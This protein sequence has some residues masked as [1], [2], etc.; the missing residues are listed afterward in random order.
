MLVV[1]ALAF[2]VVAS[3]N[4]STSIRSARE[5]GQGATIAEFGRQVTSL[6]HELQ[7]ERD[8]SAGFVSS[9]RP[10][11]QSSP[12]PKQLAQ[13]QESVKLLG[14]QVHNTDRALSAFRNARAAVERE[15]GSQAQA[16]I[17]RA[18][19]AL[20]DLGTLRNAVMTQKLTVA[21]A[22][23]QY[24]GMV[25][26]LQDV[27]LEIGQRGGSRE[28]TQSVTALTDLSRAKEAASQV[29]GLLYS[30]AYVDGF[31]FK[32]VQQLSAAL[33]DQQAALDR[34]RADA[35]TEQRAV[36]DEQVNGQAVI[37]VRRI[38]DRAVDRQQTADLQIDPQQWYAAATTR[39]EL[40]RS[41]ESS[42]LDSVIA[43]AR[44]LRS[45]AQRSAISTG[46]VIAAI[47]V[48]ALLTSLLIARSMVRPLRRLRDGARDVAENRLPAAI[49][50]LRSDAGPAD[51]PVEPIGID[52][53]DEVGEVGLTFDAIH[54][55]AIKLATE[56]AALRSNVNAMFV[57]L[58]RRS[59]SLV[60]RQLKLIDELETGEQDPDQLSNLFK[61]DHLA[62]RM[63]RNS[64]NLLVLA[65]EDAGRRW[66]RPIPLVDVLRAA[67]S[68]VEQ[69]HRIQLT[70]VPD[71]EVMGHAVNH[72]V[73]L[74]AE[75]L[76]NAT[77]FSSPE[78]KVLVHSQRLSDGG[79]MIEIEDRG[80]GMTAQEI[81]DAN[82]R[83]AKPPIFDVSISR[84]MGLFVV[85]RLAGRHGI[86]VRLRQSELGGVSAFV[87]ISA[88]VLASRFDP[89]V[90]EPAGDGRAVARSGNPPL[91]PPSPPV[92]RGGPA[93]ELPRR[94]LPAVASGMGAAPMGT[95]GAGPTGPGGRGPAGLGPA[96]DP[97]SGPAALPALPGPGAGQRPGDLA[98]PPAASTPGRPNANAT[99]PGAPPLPRRI[100]AAA[101][102][103]PGSASSS[104]NLPAPDGA[105]GPP[106]LP[107]GGTAG[108]RAPGPSISPRTV[109]TIGGRDGGAALPPPGLTSPSRGAPPRDA[110]EE[111][112]LP[113]FEQLQSEW[114]RRR[115][116][117]T[118]AAAGHPSA[119]GAGAG[120]DP[121]RPAAGTARPAAVAGP[122][123]GPGLRPVAGARPGV[124]AGAGQGAMAG[125]GVGAGPGAWPGSGAGAR[126]GP[127]AGPGAGG[128]GPPAPQAPAP[129]PVTA[130]G[131]GVA[132]P[133]P[134]AVEAE[135]WES[136]A[137]EGWRAAGRLLAPTT[138]GVTRAGLP[139]RV[140][141]AHLVPGAADSPL[142]PPAAQAASPS[143]SPEA[144]RSRLASY[145]Q[146]V[147][148]G[149][150]SDR[151]GENADHDPS[152]VLV[153][154]QEQ[155]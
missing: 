43:Q 45:D 115:T 58:S 147:R 42:L 15:A 154:T 92:S 131:G 109:P 19:T 10:S 13:Q 6:V 29:R 145:H 69:Y 140:P 5:Y 125:P 90:A 73:H 99:P 23:A 30:V 64:E 67:T 123:P 39:I 3:L 95:L 12:N 11:Q 118:R 102:G 21:A 105:A 108:P 148:R 57:N 17:D 68:E 25:S 1:P 107:A 104:R 101:A 150:H 149:R 112:R 127:G 56:Q 144:V 50:R 96:L 26:T 9:R 142:P 28:L 14:A 2:L 52:S 35:T 139:M 27:D 54:R 76:E 137:D 82:E 121:T 111:I 133:V 81:S 151:P 38:E 130:P 24:T 80:I 72:V 124:A 116:S 91:P 143:R 53:R 74:V 155:T 141:Q 34:F 98:R 41:V 71:V 85:G 103:P 146:G 36:Y 94:P 46:V 136:P 61:L 77:V 117:S 16:K 89:R 33:A 4:A 79:A 31:E 47:L 44:A 132:A 120:P 100:P 49:E 119:P 8:L 66:G 65:G 20:D 113:I 37:T 62:T 86:T 83:L 126:P 63:R 128:A 114:F 110:E 70:S 97:K 51:I 40:V 134:P 129:V 78:S 22:L 32:Q 75:L 84:M 48:I 88:D 87:R 106:G 138:G 55:Q 93:G 59:Q 18:A 60:E 135:T 153:Q 152:D 122:A 7:A